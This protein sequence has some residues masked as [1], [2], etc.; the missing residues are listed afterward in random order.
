MRENKKILV[1]GATGFIGSHLC[2]KLLE[3]GHTVFGFSVSDD[4]KNIN[5]II[6]NRKFH[7]KKGDILDIKLL[8]NIVKENKIKVIFHLA[9]LL[10]QNSDFKNPFS[11]FNVNAL[12]TLN[13]LNIAYQNSVRKFIYASTMSVYSEPP[14]YLPVDENHPTRPLTIYGSSKLSGEL[15][16]SAYS[17]SLDITVLRYGGA[18]GLREHKHDVIYRFIR[19]A[20]TNK[21]ITI[22]GNGQQTTDFTYIDSIVKAS[23]SSMERNKPGI[24]NIGSGQ[25]TSIKE[26]AEKIIKTTNSKSKIV[27]VGKKTNR[28][29]RFFLD[30]KKAKKI[31]RYSPV[32]LD[33]GLAN[34][35]SEFNKPI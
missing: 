10:P 1:T 29:F 12:G 35:L 3:K 26:L 8:Q 20:L 22:Y 14:D 9:A 23:I 16:C 21:L 13:L 31:L 2:E 11:I 34:Y 5:S 19:Q 27:L 25:E 32:S 15:F 7:F 33:E 28:P 17:G 18:Y 24:Y 30:I 4:I 6:K